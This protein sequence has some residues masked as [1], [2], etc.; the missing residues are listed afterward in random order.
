[1]DYFGFRLIFSVRANVLIVDGDGKF[2]H[3]I[4][5]ELFMDQNKV[6]KFFKNQCTPAEVEEVKAWFKTPEGQAYLNEKLDQD[7]A[8]LQENRIKPLTSEIRSGKMWDQIEAGTTSADDYR[9]R[10]DRKH[11]SSWR[12]AAAVVLLLFTALFSVWS[13]LGIPG[14]QE[15]PSRLITYVTDANQQKTL[16]LSDGTVIRLN[17]DTQIWIPQDYNQ[18]TREVRLKGE[19]YFEVIHNEDKPFV[20]HTPRATIKDLG[21]AFNVQAVPEKKYVQVA[22]TDGEIS[23]WSDDQREEAA[24]QLVE[25]QFGHLDLQKGVLQIEQFGVDNYLSWM[26]GRLRYDQARL[27]QVSRQLSRIYGASFSYSNISLK[28]LTLTTDFERKSSFNKVLEVIAMTLRIDYQIKGK[29]VIWLQ[30]HQN[31]DNNEYQR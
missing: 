16:T 14:K 18:L 13:Y 2:T 12:A 24:T 30:K 17:S 1:M 23:V 8:Y 11:T 21:T 10:P 27:D 5:L 25:G 31:E 9:Y 20:V 28:E 26:N 15:Q 29:E 22:V 3:T 7:I 19:A 6:E 4:I